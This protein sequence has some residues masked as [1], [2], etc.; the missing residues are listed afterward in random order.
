VQVGYYYNISAYARN[1]YADNNG[2][3][4][5]SD[6]GLYIFNNTFVTNTNFPDDIK[7][8]ILLFPNPFSTQTVLKTDK[9]LHSAT[10]RVYNG[11]GQIVEQ[12]NNIS[13][14]TITFNRNN[15]QSGL[16]FY[17]LS[18]ENITIATDKIII[19]DK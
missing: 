4:L 16:Y 14:Q 7:N 9:L 5:V 2:I 19:T 15:L 13:G 18:E 11:F 8:N 10:L 1:V 6:Y 3:Y 17:H 12:I